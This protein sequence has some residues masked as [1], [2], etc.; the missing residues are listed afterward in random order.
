MSRFLK[1]HVV[2]T[3]NY[4]LLNKF[5][6]KDVSKL[7]VLSNI[8]L[9]F[10]FKTYSSESLFISLSALEI[11]GSNKCYVLK[12]KTSNVSLKLRKGSPIG[13]KVVLRKNDA[14]NF[15]VLLINTLPI[16]TKQNSSSVNKLGYFLERFI[17]N[18]LVLPGLSGNYHFFRKL[19]GLNV[20]FITTSKTDKELNYLLRSYK[21]K[22]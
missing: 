11:I 22:A 2:S 15:I 12:T 19:G 8:D 5:V 6:Y 10:R 14:L 7:P 21:L 3:V 20:K 13:C 18:P 1:E 16:E 4:D 9:Q 17:S